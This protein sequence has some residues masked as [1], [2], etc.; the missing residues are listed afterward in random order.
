VAAADALRHGA[1]WTRSPSAGSR[2]SAG[3]REREPP[4]L[5][6]PEAAARTTDSIAALPREAVHRALDA[7]VLRHHRRVVD[8][9][10]AELP[11]V[12][13][14]RVREALVDLRESLAKEIEHLARVAG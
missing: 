7:L 13:S 10:G 9:I 12:R 3:A 1:R 5:A 11:S 6:T 4:D 14:P 8:L 2:G